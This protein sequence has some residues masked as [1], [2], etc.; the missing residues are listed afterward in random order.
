MLHKMFHKKLPLTKSS[1]RNSMDKADGGTLGREMA[2][3]FHCDRYTQLSSES[4]AAQVGH[5]DLKSPLCSSS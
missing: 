5:D 3:V 4:R 2:A 1:L